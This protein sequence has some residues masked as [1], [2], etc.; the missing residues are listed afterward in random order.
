MINSVCVTGKLCS[1]L[2]I[3]GNQ[4]KAIQVCSVEFVAVEYTWMEKTDVGL[5]P[6]D[7]PDSQG[8]SL[9]IAH[10]RWKDPPVQVGALTWNPLGL[11]SWEKLVSL[12]TVSGLE[13]FP[14]LPRC[15]SLLQ[16]GHRNEPPA[17]RTLRLPSTGCRETSSCHNWQ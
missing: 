12:S 7:N 4:E 10:L 13:G 5:E 16:S 2:Y 14:T 9:K 1:P 8:G 11:W 6:G 15:P 17:T 3:E